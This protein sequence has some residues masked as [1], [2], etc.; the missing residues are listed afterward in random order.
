MLPVLYH[1][2]L[3]VFVLFFRL[4]TPK[5][6]KIFVKL[7]KWLK[8]TLRHSHVKMSLLCIDEIFLIQINEDFNIMHPGKSDSMMKVWPDLTTQIMPLLCRSKDKEAKVLQRVMCS[9]SSS[10]DI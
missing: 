10:G 2:I 7:L 6:I 9:A 8:V 5:I 1:G 3:A 4:R